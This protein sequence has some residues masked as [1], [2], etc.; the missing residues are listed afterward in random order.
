MADAGRNQ[1]GRFRVSNGDK[2]T[3]L[4]GNCRWQIATQSGDW[5]VCNHDPQQQS[6]FQTSR[7]DC[8]NKLDALRDN[9]ELRLGQSVCSRFIPA[10]QGYSDSTG[11]RGTPELLLGCP[12]GYHIVSGK[13]V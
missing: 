2:H 12:A 8:H 1:N 6:S 4:V 10:T 11:S 13:S 3:S 5:G 7:K 9:A